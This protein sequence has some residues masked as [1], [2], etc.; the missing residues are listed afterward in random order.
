MRRML[1]PKTIGGGGSTAKLYQ[2]TINLYSNNYG[3][4]YMTLYNY[5][6][7][8]IDSAEKLNPVIENIHKIAATGYLTYNKILFNAYVVSY[9]SYNKKAS[10]SGYR[11]NTDSGNLET[12]NLEIDKFSSFKDNVNE[13]R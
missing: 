9:S 1:D 4:S 13:V 8:A 10:V 5:S 7:A 12:V 11:I 3:S 6:N 2:H